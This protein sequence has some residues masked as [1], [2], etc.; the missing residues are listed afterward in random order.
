MVKPARSRSQSRVTEAKAL[1]GMAQSLHDFYE[2]W[3]SDYNEDLANWDYYAVKQTV[4]IL[5]NLPLLEGV[6][7]DARDPTLR[8]IDVGC[9]TGLVG[10]ELFRKGY[11]QIDGLD[12]SPGMIA[13]AKKTGAF[14]NLYSGID[15]NI[16]IERK[17]MLGQYD[18]AVSAGVFTPG[19]V[20]PEALEHMASLVR[21]GGILILST[22]VEY[23]EATNFKE[24]SKELERK[25]CVQL[26]NVIENAPYA[27][28]GDA[29]YWVFAVP[30]KG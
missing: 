10:L 24:V 16:P 9:G 3:A 23:C 27:D 14:K 12:L 4:D 1:D 6:K 17:E 28:D 26:L 5:Q 2:K 8:I 20:A 13:E 7:V 29:H 15:L 19:H 21:P 11:S 18:C 25:N 22:R 30:N